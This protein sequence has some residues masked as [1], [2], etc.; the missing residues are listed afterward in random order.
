MKISP[1]GM[2]AICVHNFV[3][4]F[5]VPFVN[6]FNCT[7]EGSGDNPLCIVR[8]DPEANVNAEWVQ[9]NPQTSQI[10]A[11]NGEHYAYLSRTSASDGAASNAI[12]K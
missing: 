3:P 11:F 1:P 5:Q 9:S 7:F 4:F 10:A 6:A 8:N 12:A 2:S